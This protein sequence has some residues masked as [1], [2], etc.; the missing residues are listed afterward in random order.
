M[1]GFEITFYEVLEKSKKRAVQTR[2]ILKKRCMTNFLRYAERIMTFLCTTVGFMA[3]EQHNVHIYSTTLWY[4][5]ELRISFAHNKFE[6]W[7]W[8]T[9]AFVPVDCICMNKT[10]TSLPFLFHIRT[11]WSISVFRAHISIRIMH[12]LVNTVLTVNYSNLMMSKA[13]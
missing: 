9:E 1:N 7:C 5:N 13:R 3:V 12:T 10:G 11:F 8:N 4:E 6:E 2:I